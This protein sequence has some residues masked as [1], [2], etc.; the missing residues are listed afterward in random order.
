MTKLFEGGQRPFPGAAVYHNRMDYTTTGEYHVVT[1]TLVWRPL[2]CYLPRLRIPEEAICMR[3]CRATPAP[4]GLATV[5][6][7][8]PAA[9]HWIHYVWADPA[10]GYL[11]VRCLLEDSGSVIHDTSIEYRRGESGEWI[12]V[13]WSEKRF[14]SNG[15]LRDSSQ[16]RVLDCS[17][18]QPI[19]DRAFEIAIP[20]GTWVNEQRDGNRTT[21]LVLEDGTRRYLSNHE[22]DVRLYDELMHPRARKSRPRLRIVAAVCGGFILLIVVAIARISCL[23]TKSRGAVDSGLQRSRRRGADERTVLAGFQDAVQPPVP[24]ID[25][26]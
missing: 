10:R 26:G 2:A 12:P 23:R 16:F 1:L 11:P 15:R 25:G 8:P 7:W 22:R 14:N 18:D 21:Y 4:E 5:A 19:P 6:F 20:H 13:G 17:I 24:G 9:S 3:E